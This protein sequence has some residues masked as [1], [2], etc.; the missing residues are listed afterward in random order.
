MVFLTGK[1]SHEDEKLGFELGAADYIHKPISIPVLRSRVRTHLQNKQS[2][3]FLRVQ[4][5]YLET[6]VLK[7]SSELDRMQNAV[8]FALASLAE[9]RDPETGNHTLGTQHC[10]KLLAEHLAENEKYQELLTSKKI[11]T[12]F[13]ATLLH[14]IG[15]VGIID[16]ILLKS[17][18]ISLRS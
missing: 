13:K 11:D 9:T 6:K 16:S 18:K 1:D 8:V 12:Y 5:G 14:D 7:R 3:D 10:V 4:N 2:K 17:G 15:K